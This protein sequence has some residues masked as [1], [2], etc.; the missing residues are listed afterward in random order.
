[1]PNINLAETVRE[2]MRIGGQTVDTPDARQASL[3]L[4]LQMEELAEKLDALLSVNPFDQSTLAPLSRTLKF[5]G[6]RAKE[7]AYMYLFST[8]F[9]EHHEAHEQCV[10]ADADLAWVALGG[11]MCSARR[12][13]DVINEVARANMDKY[14]DGVAMRDSNGKIQKPTGW[15]GPN[16]INFL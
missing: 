14:P 16:H 2:F 11:L 8:M 6:Q 3:Y 13:L 4:G 15:R 7:G 12:P 5:A 1:M 10:D 9:R